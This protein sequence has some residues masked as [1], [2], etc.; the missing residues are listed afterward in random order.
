L[1]SSAALLTAALSLVAAN[2]FFFAAGA[3]VLCVLIMRTRIEEEN[4]VARFGDSY[5][6]YMAGTGRFMPKIGRP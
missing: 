4:L 2:W 6:E 1:Y 5:R 3:A